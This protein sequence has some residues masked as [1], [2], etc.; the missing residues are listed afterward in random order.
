[1]FPAK[2]K[3]RGHDGSFPPLL[4]WTPGKCGQSSAERILI[5]G[6]CK[7]LISIHSLSPDVGQDGHRGMAGKGRKRK[8]RH[9]EITSFI[10]KHDKIEI[11]T[12]V[13]DPIRRNI[14]SLFYNIKLYKQTKGFF[15][16]Q[17]N[18]DWVL[19]WFDEEIK[20][21]TGVDV[22]KYPFGGSTHIM[23]GKFSIIIARCDKLFENLKQPMEKVLNLRPH[24]AT[25]E[26][27]QG[28]V[29]PYQKFLENVKFPLRS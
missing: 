14:S 16:N 11:V 27:E 5:D 22:Y 13:R 6:G 26:N 12:L 15:L 8:N 17:F 2:G 1:M 10:D 29:E 23:E 28:S 9:C 24:R 19:N 25:R 18:H 20:R 7:N 21:Y 4:L 3:G